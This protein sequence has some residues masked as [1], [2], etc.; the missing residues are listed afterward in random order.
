MCLTVE[1]DPHR[2]PGLRA[3]R[4]PDSPM[5]AERGHSCRSR[6]KVSSIAGS[7]SEV[8][9]ER[10]GSLTQLCEFGQQWDS[11]QRRCPDKH[12]LMDHRWVS[13]WLKIFATGSHIHVLVIRSGGAVVGLVPLTITRSY[14]LFPAGKF[15]VHTGLDYRYSTVP[16]FA[17]L[18]PVRRLSF[19]LSVAVANRRSHFLF[20]EHDPRFYTE[21]MNYVRSIA[22]DWDLFVIE[23]FPSG[24]PQEQLLLDPAARAGLTRDGRKG[25]RTSMFANLPDSMD[26]FLAAKSNHFRKR[27]RAECRQA[28][29]RF[30]DLRLREFRGAEIEQGIQRI[31]ALEARSWKAKDTR[32]RTYYIAPDPQL[33]TFHRE[34][35]HAFAA[36][37][38]ALVL[39]MDLGERSVAG[40]YCVERDGVMAAIITFR[41]EEFF[42]R[43]TAAPLFRRLVEIAIERGLTELDFNGNSVN[44]E[45][46]ADGNRLSSRFYFYNHRPYSRFLR[47]LART[48]HVARAAL[49][50]TARRAPTPAGAKR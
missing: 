21:I 36:T 42:D 2:M 18:V 43:L 40:I 48:A 27:L 8:Q 34:V 49:S 25:E 15:H 30:P 4:P 22:R 13:T 47:T 39:T 26:A 44:I 41:D 37:D 31:F 12:V 19:P 17:R 32:K 1:I 9:V 6:H 14:E 7:I 3:L 23:G 35:A 50:S 33:E 28:Q 46:W 20:L 24:S 38:G 16:R 5:G 11:L 45:K 29:E 10:I